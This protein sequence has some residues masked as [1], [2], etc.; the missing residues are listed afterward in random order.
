[1]VPTPDRAKYDEE[2]ALSSSTKSVRSRDRIDGRTEMTDGLRAV[3][4]PPKF[5]ALVE[6][7]QTSSRL[8]TITT[9]PRTR[10]LLVH[11]GHYS[12]FLEGGRSPGRQ[13]LQSGNSFR[14]PE[15]S[16]GD[17]APPALQRL[18]TRPARDTNSRSRLTT[19][20][21]EGL[22]FIGCSFRNC[23][24][25]FTSLS[26]WTSPLILMATGPQYSFSWYFQET[27][28]NVTYAH[29]I[30]CSLKNNSQTAAPR[31][32]LSEVHSQRWDYFRGN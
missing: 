25:T 21:S 26:V 20:E 10:V 6:R 28:I 3:L 31:E 22:R 11:R 7:E 13:L 4:G 2:G 27:C 15:S 12:L 8:Q 23:G 30:K 19:D 29:G 18:E 17:N 32:L 14:H 16:R 1:M 24:S 5:T 9:L